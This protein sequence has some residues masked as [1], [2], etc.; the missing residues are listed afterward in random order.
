[1][2]NQEHAEVVAASE[3]GELAHYCSPGDRVM[4]ILDH[5]IHDRRE[6]VADHDDRLYL[7]NRLLQIAQAIRQAGN[8]VQKVRI[9]IELTE[10]SRSVTDVLLQA[11]PQ[12]RPSLNF[13]PQ[14]G[15]AVG[16]LSS[17]RSCE[18]A[19]PFLL[20]SGKEGDPAAK[21]ERMGNG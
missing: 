5:S 1:M 12:H 3:R 14:K 8:D 17:H 10:P 18:S 2:G 19:L 20:A 13:V 11:Q 6:R 15:R 21:S 4:G 16:D 9:C 7:A